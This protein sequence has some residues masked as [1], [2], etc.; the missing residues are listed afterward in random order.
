MQAEV[1]RRDPDLPG[2]VRS[3]LKFHILV[4]VTWLLSVDEGSDV[5]EEGDEGE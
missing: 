4:E 1:Y 2:N 3:V 5:V